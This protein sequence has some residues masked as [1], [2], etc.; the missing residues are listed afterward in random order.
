MNRGL[1]AFLACVLF[2]MGYC[3]WIA[4]M[5]VILFAIIGEGSFAPG[6]AWHWLIAGSIP[7]FLG[8]SIYLVN[9]EYHSK[10]KLTWKAIYTAFFAWLIILIALDVFNVHI[11]YNV[12]IIAG[13]G[14]MVILALILKI[15]AK[16]I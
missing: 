14:I 10:E 5:H 4:L 1:F 13:Y 12:N 8:I 3:S 6:A 7:V 2:I 15:R 16:Y 9:K 11:P